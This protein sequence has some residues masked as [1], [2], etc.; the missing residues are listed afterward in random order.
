MG[1]S[2][3][4]EPRPVSRALEVGERYGLLVVLI[5]A[6][7]G[8]WLATPDTFGSA[9]NL[10]AILQNQTVNG[11]V[12][13]ALLVPLVAK[14]FDISVGAIAGLAGMVAASVMSNGG[15]LLV[16]VTAAVAAS[17][18]IGLINGLLV[19]RLGVNSLIATIGTAT[20]ISGI[21]QAYTKG[22]P[23]TSGI[24]P[25]LTGLNSQRVLGIP[26][27]F[28]LMGVIALAVWYFL[29]QTPF[30]RELEAVGSNSDS[31]RLVGIPVVRVIWS[32]FLLSA[33]LAAIGGLMLLARQGSAIPTTG[34]IQTILPALAAVF[35]G[36]TSIRPGFYNVLGTLLGLYLVGV[37]VSGLTLLGA[38]SWVEPVFNGSIIVI[39]VSLSTYIGRRRTGVVEVGT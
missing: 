36:A 30:G 34:G 32:S 22:V 1:L 23:I 38:Q 14:R 8:F 12:A 33:V 7:V 28:L 13:L 18:V 19:A 17:A 2:T 3:R 21:V 31:A 9:A 15:S 4:T 39:A 6:A 26:T 24:S 11:V 20:V 25:L 29:R 5:V 16:G 27:L 10:R 37:T 35:L